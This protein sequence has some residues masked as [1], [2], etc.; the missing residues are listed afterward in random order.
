MS[1]LGIGIDTGGT[2]T[3]AVI[4]RFEDKEILAS[5]KTHTTHD[6]LA[7][8]IRRALERLPKDLAQQA[9]VVA[10]STTLATNACVENKG[11]RAKVA[12]F[13]AHR[14]NVEHYGSDYG[15]ERGD[16]IL[17]V[18]SKTR[19]SGKI[20][21]M[22]DW[23]DF[24][25]EVK[26]YF[27]DCDAAGVVE[28]YANKTGGV[29]ENRAREII[30]EA[31]DIPVVCG[32]ELFAEKN[33]IKRGANTLLNARLISIIEEFT[34][35]VRKSLKD[36]GIKAPFVIVRSDGS[37]MSEKFAKTHPIE[38]LL[39]GP[40][41]SVKGAVE[42]AG[43]MDSMVI[44]I[45]GTT[46]DIALVKNHQ[47]KNADGGVRIGRWNTFVKG[48]FVDTFGLGG[49]SG[50][51]F[52]DDYRIILEDQRVIPLCMTAHRYPAVLDTLEKIAKKTAPTRNPKDDIFLGEKVIA[53]SAGY[54]DLEK[55]IATAL[56]DHP[57]SLEELSIACGQSI[58][59]THLERL[60]RESVII[61]CGITP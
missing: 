13:G 15:F 5:T 36:L 47:P 42:L 38:T 2:C 54:S 44:D 57:M 17:F 27:K 52:D 30:K 60:V 1:G 19:P 43:D 4:Y 31:F 56:L 11:G 14:E 3:D 32:N 37:L 25:A 34:E 20:V 26:D 6:D 35:A 39:C 61:R 46:T 40:V 53:E 50:V 58:L 12:M 22:P 23:D 16:G 51:T 8:G 10:L 41:A 48:L 9:E 18:D 29:L 21:E 33:I 28:M 7:R 49:D 55:R 59:H 24:A 45:G